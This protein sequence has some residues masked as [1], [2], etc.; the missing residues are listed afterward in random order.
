MLK[1]R[2]Y[3]EYDEYIKF[4]IQKTTDPARIKKW[5]GAEWL[6]KIDGFLGEFKRFPQI[7]SPEKKALCLGART[8]QE[9]VALKEMGIDAV[10]IDLVPRLPYVQKGDMHDLSFEDNSFD[11]V[12]SNVFDHS[13]YPEKFCSEIERVLKP[14]G[15]ALLQFQ[16]NIHQDEFTEVVL[17]DP[18]LDVIPLFHNSFCLRSDFINQNFAGMNY[19]IVML[20]VPEL[21]A[22]SETYGDIS[23]VHVPD[24]YQNIWN[25]INLDIQTQKA[26]IHGLDDENTELILSNL[27]KRAYYLTVLAKTFNVRNIA[28][29]GT[30][31]GWQY[32]SFAEYCKDIGGK[33]WSC[34]IR[35]VRNRSYVKKYSDVSHFVL[36]TSKEMIESIKAT[37]ETID[38]FYIDGSH[39]DGAV[40]NDV[41]NLIDVQSDRDC[42][43]VFDDYDLRFG[44]HKDLTSIARQ[45]QFFTV[46]TPGKTASNNPTHQLVVIGNFKK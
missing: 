12:F 18:N 26:K 22:M 13:I 6:P 33:V 8:G 44:C 35:D 2:A 27:S 43:W 19:E 4:Q 10:G 15:F 14:Q 31:Q 3:D 38:M 11:I 21:V 9:V 28:E 40:V 16:V 17:H 36:G 45:C 39:D 20:K 5:T 1:V 42:I 46:H 41:L 23:N 30:A 25:D 29:V 32:F 24:D 34:D 37:N 7:F